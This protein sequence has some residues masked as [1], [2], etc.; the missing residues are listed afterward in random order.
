MVNVE[1]VT[2]ENYRIIVG[3]SLPSTAIKRED[4]VYPGRKYFK[5]MSG[6]TDLEKSVPTEPCLI[7]GKEYIIN[8]RRYDLG[9]DY[10]IAALI[11]PDY[12]VFPKLRKSRGKEIRV[13]RNDDGTGILGRWPIIKRIWTN[14]KETQDKIEAAQEKEESFLSKAIQFNVS[15]ERFSEYDPGEDNSEE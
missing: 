4:D 6:T 8:N 5:L 12:K 3:K 1:L 15:D 11:T 10:A 9:E 2:K 14:E 13:I 7:T